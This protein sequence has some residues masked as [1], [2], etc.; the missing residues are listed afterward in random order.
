MHTYEHTYFL[1]ILMSYVLA[2]LLFMY[3]DHYTYTVIALLYCVC[4]FIVSNDTG[5]SIPEANGKDII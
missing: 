5:N 1:C 4:T 2:H 3:V